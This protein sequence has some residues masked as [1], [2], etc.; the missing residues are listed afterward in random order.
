MVQ[1]KPMYQAAD[2]AGMSEKTARKY[3]KSKKLPSELKK[4]HNWKTHKNAFEDIWPT[5]KEMLEVNAGLEATTLLPYLQREY[6]EQYEE[7]QLRTLQRR[8]KEWR[9]TEGPGKEVMFEQVHYPGDLSQS[10]FT[11]MDNLGI[12]ISGEHFKHMVYHF[13][14]TY[15]N[16]EHATICFSESFESYSQ[17]LQE[18]L[19]VLGG[20]PKRHQTDQMSLAV[21]KAESQKVFTK[22]YEG[23]LNHYGMKGQKIQVRKPNEN[24]DVEQGHHRFKRA[25]RQELMLRGTSDFESRMAYSEFLTKLLKRLNFGRVTKFKEDQI[26][27]SE[28][29]LSKLDT[30]KHYKVRVRSGSTISVDRNSYSVNSRL[31]GEKVDVK[32]F[33]EHIEIWLGQKRQDTFPRLIGRGKAHINYGHIINSLVKK[34]GAFANYRHQDA[35]FPSSRFRVAYDWLC[36]HMAS[37]SSKEYLKILQLAASHSETKVDQALVWLFDKNLPIEYEFVEDLVKN[38]DDLPSAYD[39]NVPEPDIASYDQL[40]VFTQ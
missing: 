2:R 1:E 27:L 36:A 26:A 29:P 31:I 8:I 21:Q 40:L 11:H 14:L 35:L 16:W 18:S 4:P 9:A 5:I 34:P 24:G 25:V 33:A 3:I 10:D 39:L 22:R 38:A 32:M 15:S 17:G 28:L 13:V 23:L 12:T 19:W 20:V 30:T 37:K 6:P 7:P